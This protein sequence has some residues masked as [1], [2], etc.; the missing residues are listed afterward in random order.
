MVSNQKKRLDYVFPPITNYTG[1]SLVQSIEGRERR[2]GLIPLLSPRLPN[3][4]THIHI[5]EGKHSSTSV[6]SVLDG[7][8][9]P[10]RDPG[11]NGK[12]YLRNVDTPF[13]PVGCK[14]GYH[15]FMYPLLL[16]TGYVGREWT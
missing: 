1:K 14:W 15:H 12:V 10:P 9:V 2:R 5:P 11:T 16:E 13:V 7:R 4:R 6:L 3:D 8:W